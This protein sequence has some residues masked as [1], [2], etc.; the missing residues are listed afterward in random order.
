MNPAPPVTN[1]RTL[2]FLRIRIRFFRLSEPIN[3]IENYHLPDPTNTSRPVFIRIH[4]SSFGLHR[5]MY[6]RSNPT[7]SSRFLPSFLPWICQRQ[8]IP[9]FTASFCLWCPLKRAYSVAS[10]GLGP[11]RLMSPLSTL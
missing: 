4:K 8:V 9:G 5:P 11:T 2:E 10:G 7:H 1:T 3:T 6:S